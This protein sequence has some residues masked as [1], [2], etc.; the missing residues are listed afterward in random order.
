MTAADAYNIAISLADLQ[1]QTIQF[2]IALCTVFTGWVIAGKSIRNMPRLSHD[3]MIL[4]IG[5]CI[6]AISTTYAQSLLSD[7]INAALQTARSLAE[8]EPKVSPHIDTALFTTFDSRINTVPMAGVTVAIALL[9]I[10][11]R[12]SDGATESGE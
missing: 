4:T 12:K 3:R 1:A 6:P 5:F 7:R 2:F 10:L 9:S 11:I 8:M